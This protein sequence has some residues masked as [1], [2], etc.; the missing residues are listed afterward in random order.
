[1]EKISRY[2]ICCNERDRIYS[3]EWNGT[4]Q[5]ARQTGGPRAALWY[6][7]HRH[8]RRWKPISINAACL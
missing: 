7:G 3:M 5:S 2:K 6:H 4:T 1:L 8:P